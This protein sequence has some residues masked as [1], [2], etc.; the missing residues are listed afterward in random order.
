MKMVNKQWPLFAFMF[1]LASCISRPSVSP[2][3]VNT[4][5]VEKRLDG[6]YLPA[7]MVVL[8]T[9]GLI[10]A[11]SVDEQATAFFVSSDNGYNWEKTMTLKHW[12]CTA[13]KNE[14]DL[15]Y[16]GI[17]D[18]EHPD[19]TEKSGKMLS[20][21]DNGNSWKEIG[22]FDGVIED[23]Q[24]YGPDV[25][26]VQ[27]TS[28]NINKESGHLKS[29][30]IRLLT[31]DGGKTWKS[32]DGAEGC[33][34]I[35][36]S[37]EG[38]LAVYWK[39]EGSIVNIEPSIGLSTIVRGMSVPTKIIQGE[40]IVG[41]WNHK[42]ADYFRL[43]GDSAVYASRIRYKGLFRD[44]VPERIYQNGDL[45]Y[46]MVSVPGYDVDERMFVSTDRASNW[47]LV[48]TETSTDKQFDT[49]YSPVGKAW[50]MAG[51]GDK[52]VSYCVGYKDDQRGDFI[53]VISP[54][55]QR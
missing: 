21:E 55:N 51:Y 47:R 44:H 26:V 29:K 3:A 25:A 27:M 40:D 20:S 28:V 23:V 35:F 41:C 9:C 38:V 6:D 32:L 24:M 19:V 11:W 45:V 16:C 4:Y 8:P 15:I 43:V 12:M 34:G 49:V 31:D 17:Y 33:D 2:V 37:R 39:G 13:L 18:T 48:M 30:G 53:K 50:F 10:A 22:V 52:M 14:G 1:I 42:Y 36:L 54:K 5:Y 46:T 7:Y